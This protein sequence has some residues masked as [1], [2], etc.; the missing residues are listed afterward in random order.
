MEHWIGTFTTW[1]LTK[2]FPFHPHWRHMEVNYFSGNGLVLKVPTACAHTSHLCAYI[3]GFGGK[4]LSILYGPLHPF[5]WWINSYFTHVL[6][7]HLLSFKWQ[8]V[9]A[10]WHFLSKSGISIR[11]GHCLNSIVSLIKHNLFKASGQKL[12]K[13]ACINITDSLAP[14]LTLSPNSEHIN[15]QTLSQKDILG[16]RLNIHLAFVQLLPP[17]VFR[18]PPQII[19]V[20]STPTAHLA[21]IRREGG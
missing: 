1:Y 3:K 18:Q 20:Y 16:F 2:I 15:T 12:R 5:S 14:L 10:F 11:D 19:N 8:P 13:R 9:K 6:K 21:A 4:M 17:S 7:G